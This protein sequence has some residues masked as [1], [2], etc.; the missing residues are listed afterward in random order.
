MTVN[1]AF[2][3]RLVLLAF[4]W[5][6]FFSVSASIP[7]TRPNF[8]F[9]ALICGCSGLKLV[10]V[11]VFCVFL[12]TSRV[13]LIATDSVQFAVSEVAFLKEQLAALNQKK[14]NNQQS[15]EAA[16]INA[17][18]R[19]IR[20]CGVC[21]QRDESGHSEVCGDD[22]H[23]P[24]PGHNDRG[25]SCKLPTDELKAR[26]HPDF[27]EDQKLANQEAKLQQRIAK[28]E[29]RESKKAEKKV[30]AIVCDQYSRRCRQK[31]KSI[32]LGSFLVLLR[33]CLIAG[34][35]PSICLFI[36]FGFSVD[37]TKQGNPP[38]F[39][40][41]TAGLR[42]LAEQENRAPLVSQPG[43]VYRSCN[44]VSHCSFGSHVKCKSTLK[45]F[46]RLPAQ[47][48]VQT[49]QTNCRQSQTQTARLC[50]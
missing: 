4:C 6:D 13:S 48:D 8:V 29:A 14:Q 43:Q 30:R 2:F 12:L 28:A 16:R 20:I 41:M 49:L 34:T 22:K 33:L 21:C 15:S 17:A 19:G 45:K 31:R 37:D 38:M 24:C 32:V 25:K 23:P 50:R 26:K 1:Y 18:W 5:V 35:L 47:E 36:Y 3:L 11:L 9:C 10:F 44:D 39:A 27:K 42:A 40:A 7:E 46:W